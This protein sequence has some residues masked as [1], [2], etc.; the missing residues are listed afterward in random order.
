MHERVVHLHNCDTIV[1]VLLA[2]EVRTFF[3]SYSLHPTALWARTSELPSSLLHRSLPLARTFCHRLLPV[4]PRVSVPASATRCGPS[5]RSSCFFSGLSAVSPPRLSTC[6]F[7]GC[8]STAVDSSRQTRWILSWPESLSRSRL[9]SNLRQLW[10]RD[11][12]AWSCSPLPRWEI[13][14]LSAQTVSRNRA[15]SNDRNRGWS[16]SQDSQVRV[17]CQADVYLNTRL[18]T[19]FGLVPLAPFFAVP[20]SSTVLEACQH[21]FW[22][23][24]CSACA[25]DS[26]VHGFTRDSNSLHNTKKFSTPLRFHVKW[27]KCHTCA[28]HVVMANVIETDMTQGLR[29]MSMCW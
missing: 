16:D 5:A 4:C 17:W 18:H 14:P 22:L 29:A 27:D 1:A 13:V 6:V 28:A 21:L 15:D 2:L 11:A 3:F 8:S 25:P 20:L 19:R 12:R 26:T 7:A 9:S 24:R 10:C 23:L